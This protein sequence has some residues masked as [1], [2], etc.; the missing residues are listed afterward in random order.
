MIRFIE[1]LG[2]AVV[3]MGGVIYAC[4]NNLWSVPVIFLMCCGVF[5]F[6]ILDNR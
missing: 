5:F 6:L 1:E 4:L 3:Q 2:I